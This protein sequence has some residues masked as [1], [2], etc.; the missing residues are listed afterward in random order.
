MA[1]L[2]TLLFC[3]IFYPLSIFPVGLAF[4]SIWIGQ[5]WIVRFARSWALWHRFCARWILGI[6]REVTGQFDQG[7]YFYV[8]KHES[9]FEAVET[10]ALFDRP[11][12]VMKQELLD[13]PVWGRA[14]T[15]H[16]SIG[17]NREAGAAAMR[18]LMTATKKAKATGRPIVLF[19]EGTRVPH[20]TRPELKPGFA[21]LY[22]ILGLPVIPVAH[23]AGRLW[24][25][26]FAKRSGVV[27][28]HVG[29]VIPAGLPRDE[30]EARVHAAINV[31]NDGVEAAPSLS[32]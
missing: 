14:A 20:G 31:L 22:K 4:L 23:D 27:R 9:M 19:P 32:L 29:E 7:A 13:M 26:D 6:R 2:R 8:F 18:A 28:F 16:G 30:V 11:I 12:V 24:T 10:L 5:D 21:G 3:L 17:V 15:V 1:H 25:R